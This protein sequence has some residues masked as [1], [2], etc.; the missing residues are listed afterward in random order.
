VGKQNKR[1]ER[2][3]KREVKKRVEE[4]DSQGLSRHRFGDA[5]S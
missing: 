4:R 1:E 3:R 5:D 2:E